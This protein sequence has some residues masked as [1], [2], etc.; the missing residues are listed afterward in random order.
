MRLASAEVLARA[1]VF[2][3][4][5]LD[6]AVL[7]WG[8]VGEQKLLLPP[9]G[10]VV[11]CGDGWGESRLPVS[12]GPVFEAYRCDHDP[13]G[14][15]VVSGCGGPE[16]RDRRAQLMLLDSIARMQEGMRMVEDGVRRVRAAR[17][18]LGSQVPAVESALSAHL[19]VCKSCDGSGRGGVSKHLGVGPD[20]RAGTS[21]V[22]LDEADRRRKGQ[23]EAES[24]CE[25]CQLGKSV[26]GQLRAGMCMADYQSWRRA[27]FP[28][29]GPWLIQRRQKLGVTPPSDNDG[30]Y[31]TLKVVA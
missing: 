28:D 18:A 22:S 14:E 21:G 1:V 7:L 10:M 29:R 11:G 3:K 15:R 30:N 6:R 5:D 2:A 17:V 8:F 25:A 12:G 24:A 4:Q 13:V 19:P 23:V 20:G 26:V 16:S 9:S 27:G 31:K